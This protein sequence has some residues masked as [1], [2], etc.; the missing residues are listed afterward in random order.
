MRVY[1]FLGRALVLALAIAWAPAAA[2]AAV[3]IESGEHTNNPPLGFFTGSLAVERLGSSSARLTISLT[4]TSPSANRGFLTAFVFNNPNEV[5]TGIS[6]TSAPANF[7]LVTGDDN[8]NGSPFGQFDYVVTTR[9]PGPNPRA[10]RNNGFNGGGAANRGLG[11]GVT[12]N[13]IF[14]LT[15]TEVGSLTEQSFLDALSVPPGAGEG[16]Q[17]LAVRFRGFRNGGSDKVAAVPEPSTSALALAAL[18]PLALVWWRRRP[19][20]GPGPGPVDG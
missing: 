18:V 3:M 9:P 7:S 2:R 12:G 15:G 8:V 6:M 17:S 19:D 4:N 5:I 10:D 14:E 1:R 13:F 20:P 16:V 11:V